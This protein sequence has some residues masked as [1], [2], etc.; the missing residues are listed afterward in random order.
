MEF[1][2]KSPDEVIRCVDERTGLLAQ[3]QTAAGTQRDEFENFYEPLVESLASYVLECPLERDMYAEPGGALRFGLTSAIYALRHTTNKMYT[4]NLGSEQRRILDRQYRFAAFAATIASVPAIVHSN[5][6]VRSGSNDET[7]SPYHGSPHLSGWVDQVC[8]GGIYLVNWRTDA[9]P[10][11]LANAVVFAVDIFKWGFWQRFSQIVVREMFDSIAP[12]AKATSRDSPLLRTVRDGQTSARE[13]EKHAASGPYIPVGMPVGV[14][15][16]SVA[17][18]FPATAQGDGSV[19]APGE[20]TED[21]P[22]SPTPPWADG[23]PAPSQGQPPVAAQPEPPKPTNPAHAKARELLATLPPYVVDMFTAIHKKSD[24]EQVSGSWVEV[25]D[26]TEIAV[27]VLRELGRAPSQIMDDL[28]KY[29][30]CIRRN[31]KAMIVT[32]AAAALFKG[33]VHADVP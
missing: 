1:T 8:Q 31:G 30:L 6:L 33:E 23:N 15:P 17:A 13:Y 28:E 2:A 10:I 9:L 24:F 20:L 14:T 11:S 3:L 5:V 29:K 32:Q 18:A 19:C 25:E 21:A 4:G 12:E 16:E 26:G 22:S 27:T 7:W